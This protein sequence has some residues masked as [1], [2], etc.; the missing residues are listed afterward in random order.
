MS[1][2]FSRLAQRTGLVASV[3][4]K[5][6]QSDSATP[7]EIDLYREPAPQPDPVRVTSAHADNSPSTPTR[8][9]ITM[10]L[11]GEVSRPGDETAPSIKPISRSVRIEERLVESPGTTHGPRRTDE[12]LSIHPEVTPSFE[13]TNKVNHS[14]AVVDHAPDPATARAETITPFPAPPPRRVP[15]EKSVSWIARPSLLPA[16]KR[17][18]DPA[19]ASFD[20]PRPI[21]PADSA[22]P[23]ATQLSVHTTRSGHRAVEVRQPAPTPQRMPSPAR[24]PAGNLSQTRVHIGSV[25]LEIRQPEVKSRPQADRQAILTPPPQPASATASRPISLRRLYLRGW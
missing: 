11:A 25:H 17:N 21:S 7:L 1:A 23:V 20:A 10:P 3:V 2:Y 12:T 5:S 19:G 14:G 24:P 9:S 15:P 4:R 16:D 22:K 8:S 6:V 13:L 18:S